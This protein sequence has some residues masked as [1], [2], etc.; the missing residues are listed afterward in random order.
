MYTNYIWRLTSASSERYRF[1][2]WGQGRTLSQPCPSLRST[3]RS[4]GH[5]IDCRRSITSRT[6]ETYSGLHCRLTTGW[7]T[8]AQ[9][10]RVR[11]V[12]WL[13]DCNGAA[14]RKQYE[15]WSRSS[16][17]PTRRAV[18]N[19]KHSCRTIYGRHS[20]KTRRKWN[21]YSTN[22]IGSFRRR[23]NHH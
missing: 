1:R 21:L 11:S 2:N 7:I 6:V 4:S 3:L 5:Y 19:E 10:T 22:H 13:R 18:A 15:N 20:K 12:R 17:S 16:C 8:S 23:G 14:S 9:K